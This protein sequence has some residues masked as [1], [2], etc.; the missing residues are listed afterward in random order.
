MPLINLHE[1]VQ[2][3]ALNGANLPYITHKTCSVLLSILGN[4]NKQIIL[5]HFKHLNP[6]LGMETL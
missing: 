3:S 4:P 1:L 6:P 2:V 5:Y